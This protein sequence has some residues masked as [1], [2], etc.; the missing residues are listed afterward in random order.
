M[1]FWEFGVFSMLDILKLRVDK[2]KK[3]RISSCEKIQRFVKH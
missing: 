3:F 2:Y 1:R